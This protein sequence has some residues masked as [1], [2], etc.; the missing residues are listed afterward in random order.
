MAEDLK[1]RDD[2]TERIPDKENSTCHY[3]P[4]FKG[5]ASSAQAHQTESAISKKFL[6]Q[7][8]IVA[9]LDKAIASLHDR[10]VL[11]DQAFSDVERAADLMALY[12]NA[13]KGA[14]KDDAKAATHLANSA[15]LESFSLDPTS[16]MDPI[17]LEGSKVL[18]NRGERVLHDDFVITE[19]E[20]MALRNNAADQLQ[21]AK[22]II[23]GDKA[24]LWEQ[25]SRIG[26]D[27]GIG[28]L[29]GNYLPPSDQSAA[30]LVGTFAF[31]YTMGNVAD[32]FAIMGNGG[33]IV[34]GIAKQDKDLAINGVV[35]SGVH[36]AALV[37]PSMVAKRAERP[38]K[39]AVQKGVEKL[40]KAI[41]L[42]SLQ[43]TASKTW[44]DVIYQ[45]QSLHPQHN[46]KIRERIDAIDI[47]H[48]LG[49]FSKYKDRDIVEYLYQK[50]IDFSLEPEKQIDLFR[51][52]V[53]VAKRENRLT[54][55]VRKLLSEDDDPL[56]GVLQRLDLES[57]LRKSLSEAVNEVR[58]ISDQRFFEPEDFQLRYQIKG[59]FMVSDYGKVDFA[60]MYNFLKGKRQEV[61]ARTDPL[62][63][64]RV[65]TVYH[66]GFD[67]LFSLSLGQFLS[68]NRNKGKPYFKL[69]GN[70]PE[71]IARNTNRF[72]YDSVKEV[73]GYF[74][75]PAIRGSM[76]F[77]FI[78][79]I[80]YIDPKPLNVGEMFD[81]SKL[82]PDSPL[83]DIPTLQ[84]L[85]EH[86]NSF[87]KWLVPD[88]KDQI[89][90][91]ALTNYRQGSAAPSFNVIEPR[92]ILSFHER[93]GFL[94]KHF[95]SKSKY[96]DY[97]YTFSP[98]TTHQL[99][100][101]NIKMA[102]AAIND[103]SDLPAEIT[104]EKLNDYK[105]FFE[106]LYKIGVGIEN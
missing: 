86:R 76:G 12:D 77:Q 74:E 40:Q 98:R 102:E 95:G 6:S 17:V 20:K 62:I 81:I 75:S 22:D 9:S 8:K 56:Y 14:H 31:D 61:V 89:L 52:I 59:H 68:G 96:G 37:L 70:F 55:I 71:L 91:T 93:Q 79:D 51:D 15:Y 18:N 84:D 101:S 42:D 105:D 80:A 67:H 41:D 4:A 90:T 24:S 78:N 28:Y 38:L 32:A 54:D 48:L 64:N 82:Q 46:D 34:T 7:D 11:E 29:G 88:D 69:D 53:S 33:K 49:N 103:P 94:G 72:L 104:L 58:K 66:D 47:N 16:G 23:S 85:A 35:G 26:N 57:D 63:T 39:E 83:R 21:R 27:L 25:T 99:V 92:N 13:L 5:A 45:V 43:R 30:T 97:T 19:S 1:V 106:T 2:K 65:S 3:E 10:D 60:T 87:L 100:A 73:G 50:H 44:D 36:L